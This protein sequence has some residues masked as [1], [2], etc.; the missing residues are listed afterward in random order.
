MKLFLLIICGI[1]F[2]IDS[3][4]GVIAARQKFFREISGSVR[5]RQSRPWMTFPSCLSRPWQS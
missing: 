4:G 1:V 5:D 2:L 3:R